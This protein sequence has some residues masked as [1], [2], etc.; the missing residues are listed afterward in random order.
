MDNIVCEE[1]YGSQGAKA[2]YKKDRDGKIRMI[3]AKDRRF[4]SL[5]QFFRSL[6][7][8]QGY[9][10]SV[11]GDYLTYQIWDTMQAFCSYLTGTLATQAML[12]GIGVGDESATPLAATITWILKGKN[13]L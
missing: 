6:F 8:P 7:L 12:K 1:G 4:A 5:S 9:P 10:E 13:L 2:Y 3:T 11:S